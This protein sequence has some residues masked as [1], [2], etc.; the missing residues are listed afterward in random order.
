MAIDEAFPASGI[1]PAAASEISPRGV[2][3]RAPLPDGGRELF[4]VGITATMMVH[5]VIAAFLAIYRVPMPATPVETVRTRLE[6]LPAPRPTVVA[7]QSVRSTAKTTPSPAPRSDRSSLT[8]K[9]ITRIEP[10][11]ASPGLAPSPGKEATL[12]TSSEG[13]FSGARATETAPKPDVLRRNRNPR[14]GELAPRMSLNMKR[15]ISGHQV[16]S[17]VAKTIGLWPPGYTDDPCP[18][19]QKDVERFV[20]SPTEAGR[21]QYDRNSQLMEK[22]CR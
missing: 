3:V 17:S 12:T 5:L 9:V 16:I 10:A 15:P 21:A 2:T 14:F 13:W 22:Y 18:D 4:W 7:K 6:F 19:L 1:R 20:S 11:A 8:T